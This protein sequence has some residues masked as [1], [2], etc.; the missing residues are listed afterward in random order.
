MAQEQKKKKT[1]GKKK[2]GGKYHFIF[3]F[4]RAKE[5]K[6]LASPNTRWHD[7]LLIY[8]RLH[9]SIQHHMDPQPSC[10]ATQPTLPPTTPTPPVAVAGAPPR[11]RYKKP[12][13]HRFFGMARPANAR[14]Q[15]PIRPSKALLRLVAHM[16]GSRQTTAQGCMTDAPPS[17]KLP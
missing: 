6:P 13:D 12:Y 14:P 7:P 3:T 16:K 2:I 5:E 15:K 8:P 1:R 11:R 17:L 10:P 9:A 4:C